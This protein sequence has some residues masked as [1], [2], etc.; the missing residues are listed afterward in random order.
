M[1]VP[2][3]KLSLEETLLKLSLPKGLEEKCARLIDR[4]PNDLLP[5][6][7]AILKNHSSKK[8]SAHRDGIAKNYKTA[9]ALLRKIETKMN[10]DVSDS[11]HLKEIAS[12]NDL[13]QNL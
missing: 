12:A 11:V 13:I 7:E 6:V 3:N 9:I 4:C 10:A 1:A 2:K 8:M 5:V